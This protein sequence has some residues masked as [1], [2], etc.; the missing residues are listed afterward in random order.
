MIQ[1]T[2]ALICTISFFFYMVFYP[3]LGSDTVCTD[4]FTD[5]GPLLL[6]NIY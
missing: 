6:S 2:F 4:D 1:S 3:Q 5:H